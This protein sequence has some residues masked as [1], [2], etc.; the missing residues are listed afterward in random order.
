MFWQPFGTDHARPGL[1]LTLRGSVT[2]ACV[3]PK[4]ELCAADSGHDFGDP[5]PPPLALQPPPPVF[6]RPALGGTP[7]RCQGMVLRSFG[8]LGERIVDLA[9][10]PCGTRLLSSSVSDIYIWSVEGNLERMV[11]KPEPWLQRAMISEQGAKVISGQAGECWMRLVGGGSALGPLGARS[12]RTACSDGP[13]VAVGVDSGGSLVNLADRSGVG[14]SGRCGPRNQL[15]RPNRSQASKTVYYGSASGHSTQSQIAESGCVRS[16]PLAA[17]VGEWVHLGL[18]WVSEKTRAPRSN[19]ESPK[20]VR[21]HV[22]VCVYARLCLP[23]ADLGQI[24]VGHVLSSKLEPFTPMLGRS[25]EPHFPVA[26]VCRALRGWRHVEEGAWEDGPEIKRAPQ[27][28]G[29]DDKSC[30]RLLSHAT[31]P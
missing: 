8:Q 27:S 5:P 24:G 10:S 16:R 30:R 29:L 7:G 20:S 21:L 22:C 6:V 3:R 25:F 28:S 9:A 12:A 4:S 13:G 2:S 19:G 11:V 18:A 31:C 17:R 14:R 26:S 15:Q 1:D 23:Q